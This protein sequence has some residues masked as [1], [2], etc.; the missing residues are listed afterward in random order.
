MAAPPPISNGEQAQRT[1]RMK[2][3][4]ADRHGGLGVGHFVRPFLE[5]ELEP[6]GLHGR[7][8]MAGIFRAD[9][10]LPPAG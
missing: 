10:I 9:P 1:I 7:I 5:T 6:D 8:I 4:W 2:G 3:S